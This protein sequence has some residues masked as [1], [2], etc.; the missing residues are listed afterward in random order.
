M[1]S[2]GADQLR[3]LATWYSGNLEDKQARPMLFHLPILHRGRRTLIYCSGGGHL[4]RSVY[5][6]QFKMMIKYLTSRSLAWFEKRTA[7]LP[8]LCQFAVGMWRHLVSGAIH[9]NIEERSCILVQTC[10][11]TINGMLARCC[12]LFGR[13]HGIEAS[14]LTRALKCI[15]FESET[16]ARTY[17]RFKAHV[18]ANVVDVKV[19][20]MSYFFTL[21]G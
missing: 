14:H 18:V 21:R 2:D 4:K 10:D 3:L 20:I 16:I 7:M 12:V 5:L 9:T 17:Y 15:Y 19:K 13:A 1:L 11:L 8:S 6:S